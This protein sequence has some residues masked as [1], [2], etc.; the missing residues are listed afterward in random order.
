MNVILK[1]VSFHNTTIRFNS[2]RSHSVSMSANGKRR[3]ESGAKKRAEK[4]RKEETATANTK[5]IGS[6]SP[7]NFDHDTVDTI[8]TSVLSSSLEP[9]TNKSEEKARNQLSRGKSVSKI[10]KSR[11]LT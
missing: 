2:N 10:K 4:R 8:M 1:K 9:K 7:K 11:S 6:H 5:T 3:Y